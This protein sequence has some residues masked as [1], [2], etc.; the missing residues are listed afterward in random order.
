MKKSKCPQI[1]D[2]GTICLCLIL[3]TLSLI[4][5]SAFSVE[6]AKDPQTIQALQGN[7]VGG[8]MHEGSWVTLNISFESKPGGIDGTANIAFIG[9]ENQSG[10]ALT[11]ISLKNFRTHFEMATNW[12]N[13]IFDGRLRDRTISGTYLYA[14]KRGDFGMTRVVSLSPSVRARLFGA[15]RVAPGHVTS[16]FEWVDGASLMFVDYRSGQV[17]TLY[18]LSEETFFSGSGRAVSYPVSLK[19][20]FVKDGNGEVTKLVWSP[21]GEPERTATKIKFNEEQVSFQNGEVT[22]AGTLMTPMT[23][24]PHPVMIIT[25][26]DFATSR[27]LLRMWAHNFLRSGVAALIFD[28]RGGGA[29]TGPVGSSSFSDL[30][31]DILAGVELLKTRQNIDPKR[32]GLF[33]FSN[34][35]W[36]VTLAA[37]RSKAVAFLIN[38]S[39]SGVPPWKQEIFRAERQVRLAGFPEEEVSNAVALMKLKFEVGR[40]GQG[41]EQ[42]QGML[43]RY[44]NERWLPYTNPPRSLE[45]LR[46]SWERSFSFDPAPSF[47]RVSCPVLLY[48]G[49]VDSNVPVQTSIRIV[50]QGLK[51]AGN[52]DY[53]IKV[54]PRGRHDLVEGE[55]GG[56][57]ESTRM[58]RFVP[59]YWSGMGDWL[60]TRTIRTKSSERQSSN[61]RRQKGRTS[62]RSKTDL[63]KTDEKS[64]SVCYWCVPTI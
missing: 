55:N 61:G 5:A 33:G 25:P 57:K 16:V 38:Q 24:G 39:L 2:L 49:E 41:W 60:V 7:W 21:V 14:G 17:N 62:N 30:A 15:Y 44:Q 19:V 63:R 32:I 13:I 46:A 47:E 48:Y 9:F 20:R 6:Q 37:S 51:R 1:A 54:F 34:S 10:V 22:L 53:T 23:K 36:T 35:A 12:G 27:N 31:N 18:P 59:G 52:K 3:S 50:E 43:G 29:S 45:R 56:A 26:G 64:T 4:E 40:T 28:A 42:L 58:K 11:T 8:F